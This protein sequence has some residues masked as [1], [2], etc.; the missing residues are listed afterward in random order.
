MPH[1]SQLISSVD[2]KFLKLT[3]TDDLIYSKFRE[4]FPDFN[5]KILD[6]ELLK[7]AEA[8]EVG[9]ICPVIGCVCFRNNDSK[10]SSFTSSCFLRLQKWRPFCNHFESLVEDF[11]YGTLLRLDCEKDYTEENTIFGTLS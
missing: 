7:S 8:K 3:K 11:N 4:D 9:S 10:S 6:A 5:I 2:P 1:L